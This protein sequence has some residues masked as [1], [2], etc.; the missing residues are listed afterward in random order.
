MGIIIDV[1]I[2]LF[3]LA[4]AF[5]GYKKGLIALGIQLLAFLIAIVATVIL[6]RPIGTLIINNTKIDEKL[7]ETIE[8]NVENLIEQGNVNEMTNSLIQSAENGMLPETSRNLSINI[9]YGVTMLVLY[10]AIRICLVFVKALA[11][12]MS[13]LPILNQFNELGGII[14]GLLRGVV[15]TYILLMIVNLI[16]TVNPTTKL[17][18]MIN[19]SYIAKTM[20]EYNVL[21]I[22]LD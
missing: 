16:I 12:I 18:Q 9:I 1:V 7:Q 4:S 22:F 8:S 6:Y 2:I 19:Q 15:I 3:I 17:N 11:N 10:I 20:N 21:N 13:Q 5:L 14:Y